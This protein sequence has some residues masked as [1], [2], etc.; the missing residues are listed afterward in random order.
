MTTFGIRGKESEWLMS[1]LNI[2]PGV[3][4][5]KHIQNEYRCWRTVK[6]NSIFLSDIV[7]QSGCYYLSE[8]YEL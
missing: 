2:P 7:R 8:S 6:A 4:F 1:G 3:D 5:L